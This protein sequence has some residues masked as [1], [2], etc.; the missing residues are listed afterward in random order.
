MPFIGTAYRIYYAAKNY[1]TGLTDVQYYVYKPSGARLGPYLMTE[2]N[3]GIAK[4]IYYDDFLDADSEGNHLIV[5]NC[6]TKPKQSEESVYFE[7]RILTVAEKT[8]LLNDVEFIKH[9]SGG[10]WDLS[11][12]NTLT[13]YEAGG[14]GDP[15]K[16][17]A[18]FDTFNEAGLP[19][20]ENIKRAL[21]T[22]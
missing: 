8:Q 15:A 19:D 14:Y 21:R 11:S 2:L 22:G 10:D 12:P 5:A 20:P 4:G 13:L 16:V 17:V 6:A 18:I 1:T 9:I 7:N 3:S